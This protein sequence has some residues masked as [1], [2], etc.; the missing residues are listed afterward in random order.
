MKVGILV[1]VP[2]AAHLTVMSVEPHTAALVGTRR[3]V[4]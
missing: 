2:A 3:T 1:E 4:T